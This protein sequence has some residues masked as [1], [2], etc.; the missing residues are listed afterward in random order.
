M[1]DRLS[2]T[3]KLTIIAQDPS[4]KDFKDRVLKTQIEIPAESLGR[5]PRGYRVVVTDYDSSTGTLYIPK[6]YERPHEGKYKD[7]FFKTAERDDGD[8]LLLNDPRFHCQNVYA[9]VMRTLARFEFALGRRV[10]WG[11]PGHQ[12]H[13]A[14]HAFADANAFY[15]ENDRA[16]CFGYFPSNDPE[17]GEKVIIFTC[18]SHDV[19]AH[20]TTHALLDGLRQRFTDPSSTDQAGFH[21]GFSDVVAMLSIFSLT[22]VVESLLPLVEK[23][24]LEKE[25]IAPE[26]GSHEVLKSPK[27]TEQEGVK[28]EKIKAFIRKEVKSRKEDRLTVTKRALTAENLRDS[29]LFGLA[30]QMGEGLTGTRGSALRRSISLME[31]ED[32]SRLYTDDRDFKEAHRRGELIVAAIMNSFL[33]VWLNRLAPYLEGRGENAAIDK[34]LIVEEGANAADHLLTMAIRALDYTPP[35]DIRFGDYLSAMLT[36]DAEIVPDDS[37][38]C[39]RETL[40]R[41][42]QALGIDPSSPEE[43]GTWEPVEGDFCYER[44]HFESLVHDPDEVFRFIWDNMRE[45]EIEE[46]A[47]TEVQ[48][49]RPS[50]RVAPDGFVLRETIAA[51][52]QMITL[53]A[54]ELVPFSIATPFSM[55]K[56]QEVTLFGGGTLIFDEYGKLKYHIRNKIFNDIQS[57]RLEHLWTMGY[58]SDEEY[59][60]NLFARMHLQKSLGITKKRK[61]QF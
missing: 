47:Y 2:R 57:E 15:S 23:V 60:E 33:E 18:L 61:E 43:N 13:V 17:T 4:I 50:M 56:D 22:D 48:S 25:K 10:G 41:N 51:Y 7:P 31:R 49:V 26:A 21:E 8:Q 46:D 52:V 29:I 39:Y 3:R 12:I 35:T 6:S 24:A 1:R 59:R 44:T 45:L 34:N 16:L 55:P 28:K 30:E 36:A 37:K 53:R 42:F 20:E 32:R 40:L 27:E 11:F 38:Y 54:D 14:P 9:I 19:V 58:I 5:G